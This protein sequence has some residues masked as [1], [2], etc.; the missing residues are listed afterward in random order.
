MVEDNPAD[1]MLAEEAL[2]DA[3]W[4]SRLNAV[5]DG[6]E[7]MQFLKQEASYAAAE[8]PDV[9]WLD[10]NIPGKH[11]HAVLAEIRQH[12]G[13]KTLPVIVFSSSNSELDVQKSYELF[14]NCYSVK[15]VDFS[16]YAEAIQAMVEYWGQRVALPH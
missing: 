7:A 3:S 16:A 12:P 8:R 15:E 6:I 1:I 11:G 13:L 5:K 9:V 10:L 4:P 14:A 2:A